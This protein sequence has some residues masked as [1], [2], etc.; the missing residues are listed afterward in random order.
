[1]TWVL[2]L[3]NHFH[4]PQKRVVMIAFDNRQSKLH[5]PPRVLLYANLWRRKKTGGRGLREG[6]REPACGWMEEVVEVPRFL[7]PSDATS[8]M[9]PWD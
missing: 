1:M 7:L 3:G 6:W 4:I 8:K 9:R 2:H 5:H